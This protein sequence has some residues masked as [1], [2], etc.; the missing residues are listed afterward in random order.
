M[1]VRSVGNSKSSITRR[2]TSKW[3]DYAERWNTQQ[4]ASWIDLRCFLLVQPVLRLTRNPARVSAGGSVTLACQIH[5]QGTS[6]LFTAKITFQDFDL[7]SEVQMTAWRISESVVRAV[8]HLSQYLFS[9]ICRRCYLQKVCE[10]VWSL[11]QHIP[12]APTVMHK[13]C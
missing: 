3:E 7:H 8:V 12:P 13:G 2:K 6:N 9:N 4:D 11:P 1:I 10:P 5:T